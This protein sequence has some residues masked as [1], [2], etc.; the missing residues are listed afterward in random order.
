LSTNKETINEGEELRKD[1]RKEDRVPVSLPVNLGNADCITR[2]VSAS[3]VF[4]E[5]NG[6]FVAGERI[7]FAIE[8]DSPGGKL[9]LK[10]NGEIVRVEDRNGKV[11]V[12]VKI[13]DSVMESA[14]GSIYMNSSINVLTSS[15]RKVR[16]S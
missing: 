13:V 7:D 10:C 4:L 14:E 12:A 15:A 2:D 3:G 6:S 5:S 11:G 16:Q 8:F 1:G 9:I